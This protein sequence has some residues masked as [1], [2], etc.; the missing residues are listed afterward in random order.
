LL[1]LARI[2][3]A[4]VDPRLGRTVFEVAC[5]VNNPLH[6]ETGAA[7]VYAPQKGATKEQVALLEEG[8]WIL[9]RLIAEQFT[10]EVGDLPGSG[11]AG[12]LGAG[13]RA[14]CGAG[15]EKG[16]ELVLEVVGLAEQLEGAALVITGEG[17]IDSQTQYDKAPAGVA[18]CALAKGVPCI[19]ICGSLG[20]GLEEL[21]RIG[22]DA[23]FPLPNGPLSL[24]E[25]MERGPELLAKAT[26][27]AVR[28][29]L[30]ARDHGEGT[31][32]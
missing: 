23:V 18:R 24:S 16:I 27:Q 25:A 26:E 1:E 29:F 9:D 8:L 10:L 6:G 13:M 12:G 20:A 4:G 11:A 19:A 30:A 7:K 3:Q 15:L 28:L 14:F 22:L 2:D 31:S 21:H 32:R 5:D 17:Q